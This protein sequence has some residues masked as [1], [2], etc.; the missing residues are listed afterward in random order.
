PDDARAVLSA[1]QD[2]WIELVERAAH[3]SGPIET[4]PDLLFAL[5]ASRFDALF[6]PRPRFRRAAAE[7][8]GLGV[9]R[10][11]EKRARVEAAA[12]ATPPRLRS[13][14]VPLAVPLDVRIVPPSLELG[15]ASERDA[16]VAIGRALAVAWTHPALPPLVARADDPTVAGLLGLLFAHLMAEPRAGSR[17]LSSAEARVVRERAVL[18]ELFEL[19]TDAA[20]VL[21]RQHASSSSYA[22]AAEHAV[23]DAWR[24]EVEASVAAGL[25][26]ADRRAPRRLRAA[27]LVCA[28]FAWLREHYDED[29]WR[30]PR[31]AEPLR[32]ACERGAALTVEAWAEEL[33]LT[34]PGA[35]IGARLAELVR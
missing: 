11:L 16:R 14:I 22:E 24:V 34:D 10:A 30:N 32:A 9:E 12:A 1:T 17:G 20:V 18:L 23:R 25:C 2:A 31:A 3:A 5:R 35:Q 19:R 8:A 29:F 13:S 4:W 28:L 21:A 6:D 15:L 26:L 33:G 7:L 27:R